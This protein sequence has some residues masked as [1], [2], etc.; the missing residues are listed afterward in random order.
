MSYILPAKLPIC[1]MVLLASIKSGANSWHIHITAKYVNLEGWTHFIEVDVQ[2]RDGRIP[3]RIVGQDVQLSS[4]QLFDLLLNSADT[5]WLVH[6]K[7]ESQCL[8]GGGLKFVWPSGRLQGRGGLELTRI[9][10]GQ[11][12]QEEMEE[13]L[14]R[15]TRGR[16][17][18]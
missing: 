8:T 3:A 14:W 5:F 15:R 17:Y 10:R 4:C 7:G 9:G 16:G 11:R 1:T 6:F 13:D 18:G 2:R 12:E